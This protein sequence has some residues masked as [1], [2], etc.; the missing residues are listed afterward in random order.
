ME[1]AFGILKVKFPTLTIA[2]PY[3]IETQVK[4]V[5][6]CYILLAEIMIQIGFL[7]TCKEKEEKEKKKKKNN[8]N[9]SSNNN[10]NN[11][12]VKSNL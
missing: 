11:M 8:N 2:P 5:L 12:Y 4:T 10:N 9:N 3:P 6:A 7:M 1:R